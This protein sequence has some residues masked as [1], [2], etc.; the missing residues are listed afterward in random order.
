MAKQ[1]H[2]P[3]KRL[4][5]VETWAVYTRRMKAKLTL[6]RERSK[7][8]TGGMLE[9]VPRK[10]ARGESRH[11]RTSTGKGFSLSCAGDGSAG[12]GLWHGREDAEQ[13]QHLQRGV[14]LLHVSRRAD[15]CQAF[16]LQQQRQ[17]AARREGEGGS[18]AVRQGR[19]R[20][21]TREAMVMKSWGHEGGLD[22]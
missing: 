5:G 12:L 20:E 6:M 2:K 11:V 4:R 19:G 9:Q 14:P 1:G 13:Q 10:L 16:A 8:S 18:G 22:A 3:N 17:R 21:A 15:A 7:K